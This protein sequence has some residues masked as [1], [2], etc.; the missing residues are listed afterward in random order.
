VSRFFIGF[1]AGLQMFDIK[2]H[3]PGTERGVYPPEDFRM[4]KKYG[5]NMLVTSDESLEKYLKTIITQ[6]SCEFQEPGARSERGFLF[7]LLTRVFLFVSAWLLQRRVS[8]LVLALISKETRETLERW[9]FDITLDRDEEN[10]ENNAS[11]IPLQYN[12]VRIVSLT[13]FFPEQTESLEC[14]KVTS[15]PFVSSIVS[16]LTTFT[17]APTQKGKEYGTDPDRDPSYHQTHNGQQ[18]LFASLGGKV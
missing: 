5:L 18:H 12:F 2:A 17:S 13:L 1:V 7:R 14:A 6:L 15:F 8:R 10:K 4:V 11:V 3:C 16:K 9:Q